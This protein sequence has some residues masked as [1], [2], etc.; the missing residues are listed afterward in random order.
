[1]GTGDTVDVSA[2]CALR[3]DSLD[4]PAELHGGSCPD[5]IDSVCPATWILVAISDGGEEQFVGSAV[6]SNPS[7]IL[8]PVEGHDVRRVLVHLSFEGPGV[9]VVNVEAVVM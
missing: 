5:D 2:I 1:M 7:A 6:G 4:I 3:V 8:G 9:G